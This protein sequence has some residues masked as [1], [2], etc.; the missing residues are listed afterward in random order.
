MRIDSGILPPA[1]VPTQERAVF[2]LRPSSPG[3]R[4]DGSM[5]VWGPPQTAKEQIIQTLSSPADA[6]P[7]PALSLAEEA[8]GRA[9]A[10]KPFGFFD[11]IDMINPLQHIPIVGTLYRAVTGDTI[12]PV[13]QIIGG[14]AFGGVLGAASGI[15]NAIVKEETGADIGENI[16]A[17]ATGSHAKDPHDTTIAVTNL[18][19]HQPRY[20]D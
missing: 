2:T 9:P 17:L 14:A 15:A 11:L 3:S 12:R 18:S 10:E 6:G 20:N 7:N 1:S 13:S 5:P 4:I 8:G 19:Y 16:M